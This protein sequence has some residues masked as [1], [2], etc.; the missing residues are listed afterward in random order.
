[1]K[2]LIFSIAIFF[3]FITQGCDNNET[4]VLVDYGCKTSFQIKNQTDKTIKI[5]RVFASEENKTKEWSETTV[6]APGIKKEIYMHLEMCGKNTAITESKDKMLPIALDNISTLHV[7]DKQLNINV[8]NKDNWN[9]SAEK[10]YKA[11]YLLILDD[12][13]IT[14][15]GYVNGGS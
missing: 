10:Y 12:E 15:Y 8:L 4:S 3:L 14:N 11:T 13:L 7:D 5:V 2:D 1:M 9:F 6:I